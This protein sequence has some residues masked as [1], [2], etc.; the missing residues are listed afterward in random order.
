MTS[1]ATR[2]SRSLNVRTSDVHSRCNRNRQPRADD[3]HPCT[4]LC[5]RRCR[6][7]TQFESQT[8]RTLP[9][10]LH[11]PMHTVRQQLA[12]LMTSNGQQVC[13]T[14]LPRRRTAIR[15][16][17][18]GRHP[19]LRPN[20]PLQ[21]AQPAHQP[22]HR[23]PPGSGVHPCTAPCTRRCRPTTQCESLTGLNLPSVVHRPVHTVRQ[24]PVH[25]QRQLATA[26]Q[27][28]AARTRAAACATVAQVCHIFSSPPASAAPASG[29]HPC[30]APCT[31]RC[32]S[33]PQ[34]GSR[35]G[36]NLPS[37]LHRSMHTLPQQPARLMTSHG[38]QVCKS[39][40]ASRGTGM[41][42]QDNS[43]A[44]AVPPSKP[45]SYAQPARH[46]AHRL[47]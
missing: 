14:L 25:S 3:A 36:F 40:L 44:R 21:Y 8:S 42:R 7:T 34:L 17:D 43:P 39:L 46:S 20:K 16:Q 27:P 9:L 4:A 47:A 1:A 24:R 38:Q 28:I 18:N 6:P 10:V 45:R 31:R 13:T 33:T 5:A 29:A 26:V 35:T 19:T 32:A 41:R 23:Q 22:V 37:I 2:A 15:R 30:T 12:R 11:Q